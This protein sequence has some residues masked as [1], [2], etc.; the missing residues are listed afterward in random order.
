M[1]DCVE[2]REDLTFVGQK[3]GRVGIQWAFIVEIIFQCDCFFLL[4]LVL[5]IKC[6]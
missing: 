4:I 2:I 3:F 1:V 6:Y 5:V